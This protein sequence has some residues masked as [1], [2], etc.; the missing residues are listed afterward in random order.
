M[1]TATPYWVSATRAAVSLLAA[2][3]PKR[4]SCQGAAIR[5]MTTSSAQRNKSP[6]RAEM[7]SINTLHSSNRP[8]DKLPIRSGSRAASV[9]NASRPLSTHNSV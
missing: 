4:I 9:A 5:L 8:F 1:V 7:L 6:S 3:T 2:L